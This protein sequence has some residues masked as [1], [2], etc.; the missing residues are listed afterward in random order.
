MCVDSASVIINAAWKWYLHMLHLSLCKVADV[1]R[2]DDDV[3][4]VWFH[5]PSLQTRSLKRILLITLSVMEWNRQAVMGCHLQYGKSLWA[6]AGRLHLRKDCLWLPVK[7]G[8]LCEGIWVKR[9]LNTEAFKVSVSLGRN[10]N[11]FAWTPFVGT[12]KC[13]YL[14]SPA[15]FSIVST[16]AVGHIRGYC[17]FWAVL[18]S[19]TRTSKKKKKTNSGSR[20]IC[21]SVCVH[22]VVISFTDD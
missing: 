22:C 5:R 16:S 14:L 21:I 19:R 11:C 2:I 4:G 6:A 17:R 9:C 15:S 18:S 8:N 20:S 13:V 10:E 1:L 3:T 7:A 12:C